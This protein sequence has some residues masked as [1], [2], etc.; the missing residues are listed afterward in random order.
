MKNP[1]FSTFALPFVLAAVLATIPAVQAGGG[2]IIPRRPNDQSRLTC[3][4][5]WVSATPNAVLAR[6]KSG[7]SFQLETTGGTATTGG[8]GNSTAG[9][10]GAAKDGA[11]AT[12]AAGL[13][14]LAVSTYKAALD[15]ATCRPAWTAL[16]RSFPTPTELHPKVGQ[17]GSGWAAD[18]FPRIAVVT[19]RTLDA[20]PALAGVALAFSGFTAAEEA[21]LGHVQ[22]DNTFR[23]LGFVLPA[24][25]LLVFAGCLDR[26][27]RI[28]LWKKP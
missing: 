6:L 24:W 26:Q 15:A 11:I 22:N 1:I 28:P 20:H 19:G 18:S 8:T 27:P 2:A 10:A 16:S 23:D 25:I 9:T 5:T 13:E 3:E 21:H 14:V 12:L 17:R 4:S 7:F